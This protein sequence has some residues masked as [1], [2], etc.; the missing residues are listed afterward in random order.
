MDWLEKMAHP[1][2]QAGQIRRSKAKRDKQIERL[3]RG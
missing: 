3:S 1:S 2:S